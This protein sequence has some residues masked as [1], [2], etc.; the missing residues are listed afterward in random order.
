M[1]PLSHH[2]NHYSTTYLPPE[3]HSR[4]ILS[5]CTHRHPSPTLPNLYLQLRHLLQRRHRAHGANIS[6]QLPFSFLEFSP[7]PRQ[8]PSLQCTPAT[9]RH[10]R[11]G[12]HVRSTAAAH[13]ILAP[14]FLT[15]AL[16]ATIP[17]PSLHVFG[18][19]TI[20]HVHLRRTVVLYHVALPPTNS[21]LFVQYNYVWLPTF[22]K[23]LQPTCTHSKSLV[24]VHC[25]VET[26]LHMLHVLRGGFQR[27]GC[28]PV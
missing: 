11:P 7:L 22:R 5:P 3:R 25:S 2:P 14:S 4:H 10:V 1:D 15:R 17:C 12:L 28:F 18:I 19:G 16:P 26:L 8:L 27:R 24:S 13:V 9:F 23:L 20:P 21:L 6:T